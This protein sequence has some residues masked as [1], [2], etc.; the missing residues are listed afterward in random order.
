MVSSRHRDKNRNYGNGSFPIMRF[1]SPLST[2]PGAGQ[3]RAGESPGSAGGSSTSA[4]AKKLLGIASVD[5]GPIESRHRHAIQRLTERANRRGRRER[6]IRAEENMVG[7]GDLAE[8]AQ[9]R[10]ASRQGGV[11]VEG[12]QADERI[13]H[14]I[15]ES[16]HHRQREGDSGRQA[17]QRPAGVR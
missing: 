17:R 5:G 12:A 6:K 14:A 15:N 1:A 10:R 2:G 7:I 9:G 11:V 8:P 13:A 4:E 16:R 3:G